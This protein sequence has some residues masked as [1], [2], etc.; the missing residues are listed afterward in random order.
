[1]N[2]EPGIDLSDPPPEPQVG[3]D[4][5]KEKILDMLQNSPW[6]DCKWQATG[7]SMVDSFIYGGGV[8]RILA[9]PGTHT[10]TITVPA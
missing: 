1:M 3:P 5:Y 6:M 4:Q 7:P 8:T 2:D 10:F 9:G